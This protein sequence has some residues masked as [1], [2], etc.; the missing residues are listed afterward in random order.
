[1]HSFTYFTPNFAAILK[2]MCYSVSFTDEGSRMLSSN[3]LVW[4]SE[5]ESESLIIEC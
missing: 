4:D 3:P 1:M 5:L 2:G